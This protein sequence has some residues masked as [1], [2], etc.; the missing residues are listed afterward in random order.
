MADD[1]PTEPAWRGR[2][3]WARSRS[4]PL[5]SFLQTESGSAGVLVAAIVAALIWANISVDSYESLWRTDLSIRV[6]TVGITHD[7][8]TWIDDGLMTLFFLVVGLE[9][10]REFDL[11]DLRERRRF[12]LPFA[13]GL[14]GMAIPVLIYLA[15]NAGR[16]SAHG[17]GVAMSTDTALA[18]GLLA[19]LGRDVPDRVRVFLLTVFVV[20]DLAALVVIAVVYSERIRVV[21]LVIAVLTFAVLLVVARLRM[22]QR[23]V[24]AALGLVVWAAL[25]ASGVDP[26]VAGLAI[27]LSASAYSPVRGDLEEATGLVRR[28]REQPTPELAR[29]ATAGL[30]STLSPNARLQTFYHPWTS[31]LIVPLF[32]LANAGIVLDGRFLAH[33]FTAPV[34][35]GVL[36]GYVVGKP[37]AVVGTSWAVTRIS[38]GRV[39]P[40][41]GWAAVAGSGT[42]AGIGFT[43][44]L[45]I[46]TRAFYAEQLNEAKLGALSAAFVASVLTWTV[47]RLTALLPPARR[48]RALLGDP[49][50]IQD[51]IPEVDPSRDHIR[52]PADAAI[53]VIE[54]G[55]FECPYCGR[56]EPVV[57]DLITER[58]VRYVWRHL[59][60]TDVHPQAQLAAEAAEAAAA[61]D[62]FWP[63]HDLLLSRQ[64]GLRAPDLVRYANELGLDP[65]RFHDDLVRHVH[66]T[67]IAQD[68][69]SADLSGVS[70]TPT[71]FINGQR[72][73]GAFDLQ[74]LTAAIKAA[75]AQAGIS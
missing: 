63:M 52:G 60:L 22:R 33:A 57:R 25:L 69:E 59:P 15:I 1:A 49:R 61:Q 65:D 16:S 24:F 54:F 18:L 45:L 55:D 42:I 35:L 68:V 73:Y 58:D 70:G 21:P 62:A 36:I 67:R 19:L 46:A 2:T 30:T 11:G 34:T 51:L 13:A 47:Y 71:F 27:G 12:V 6:G 50:L 40:P 7:L 3:L 66:A 26:V 38:R 53:T 39:R 31:Y 17:W 8:R 32:A 74:T 9:A 56:A 43:V 23:S 10:R 64:D 48:A 41:V 5:R 44:A 37:V 29:S 14:V 28:F 20:D 72:H 75:R 4:A